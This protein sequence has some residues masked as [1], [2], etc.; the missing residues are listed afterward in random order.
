VSLHTAELAGK[1]LLRMP[2]EWEPHEA[3][4]I[5]WPTNESDFPGKFEPIRWV[6]AEIVRVL[7]SSERVE[8]LCQNETVRKEAKSCLDAHHIDSRRVRFHIVKTNRSWLRDSAPT[9]IFYHEKPAWVRWQFN[10]WAKYDDFEL[11][12]LL[13]D[14]IGSNTGLKLVDSRRPDTNEPFVCEG[15]AIDTDGE[16]TLLVTEECFLS[17]TQVRNPGLTRKDYEKCFARSLGIERTIW[18]KAGIHGDDTHGHIDDVARFV[19]PRTVL[20]AY[21]DDISDLNHELSME[22]LKRLNL[23]SDAKGRSL[24]VVLLPMPKPVYFDGQRLPASYANFYI[25]NEVVIVPTFNDQ[26][27]RLALNIIAQ[28]FPGRAV[29]GINC[30]DLVL[31]LGTLHCLTQQQPRGV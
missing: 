1:N 25:A 22:N 24:N 2:A 3:T 16:G 10:A 20:L 21:E 13:P 15:G 30:V 6:Y 23:A 29:V 28:M 7:S 31:G 5:C 9:G 27:D 4:W 17:D 26:K 14:Y 18:L 12:A 8:I 19:G 11:D